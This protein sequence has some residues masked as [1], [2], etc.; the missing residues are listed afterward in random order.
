MCTYNGANHIE[1][2]LRS[3]AMQTWPIHLRVFDDVS[4]DDTVNRLLQH[5]RAPHDQVFRN[6]QNLGY[7]VNFSRGIR[8]AINDGYQYIA[9]ADQ[10]DIW[11]PQ[12]IA[13]CMRQAMAVESEVG[14]QTPVLVHSDL[15]VIDEH[16][17]EVA[18]SYLTLRGYA[19]N[20]E[21][22]LPM[23]LGQN[24]VMGNTILM[25]R[26]L[27]KLALPFPEQLHVHDYWLALLAELHGE[28]KFIKQ[29]LVQY[30]V[31]RT[32]A[33]NTANSLQIGHQKRSS[34]VHLSTETAKVMRRN[35]RL[36]FKEDTRRFVIAELLRPNSQRPDLSGEQH[37]TLTA[38]FDYLT[39]AKPRLKLLFYMLRAGYIKAGWKARIRFTLALLVT[40][41]YRQGE[42]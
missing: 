14:E 5:C 11:H 18:E 35:F 13:E 3:F 7:V 15:A 8:A 30:R 24:G 17:V 16:G 19:L 39:L 25:N 41:R 34:L 12:R 33:S 26:Q 36:P 27:A 1:E 10:D 4:T 20:A 42:S 22:N 32:N 29:A 31:H 40:R 38:F 23:I 28:R 9:L 6:T 2:Q 21:R 37:A